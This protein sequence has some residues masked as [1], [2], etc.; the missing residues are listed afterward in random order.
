[1]IIGLDRSFKPIWVYKILQLSNPGIGLN[2]VKEEFL[3][4]IEY[5]GKKSK[6]NVLTIIKRYYLKLERKNKKYYFDENYLQDLSLK[7]SFE[8]MK[9]I[10]LFV[11]LVNCPIAQFLQSKINVLFIDKET[12]VNKVLHEHAKET[13]GDRKI[14][15]Y[16]VGYY[17]TIL[18]E[19]EI[20]NKEKN[21]YHWQ[22]KKLNVPNHIL[23]EMLILYSQLRDDFEIDINFIRGETPFSLFNLNNLESVLM[24]YNSN[25]WVYQKRFDSKKIIIKNKYKKV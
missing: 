21:K 7:Y 25:D 20:F 13:Y 24:E 2:E 18:N 17:L 15:K 3:D 8:S 6:E 14:V 11:L 23:K 12:I 5:E 19:F 22:N 9:P 10:L 4:I 16:A 1:M